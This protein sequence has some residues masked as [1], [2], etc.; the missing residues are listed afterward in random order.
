MDIRLVERQRAQGVVLL[1]CNSES[2]RVKSRV[3]FS[4][5]SV[6]GLLLF[7]IYINDIVDSVSSKLLKFAN[8]RPTKLF[9][10]VTKPNDIEKLQIDLDK[11][12]LCKWSIDWLMLFN[13]DKCKIVHFGFNNTLASYK[14]NDKNLV[15]DKE[16]RAWSW[17]NYPEF[18]LKTQWQ[19]VK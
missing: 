16:E 7:L 1:G 4:Q 13:A 10:I 8:D 11:K 6:L 19:H 9:R 17:R 15:V 14:L 12:K 5:G 3:P 18:I 2:T